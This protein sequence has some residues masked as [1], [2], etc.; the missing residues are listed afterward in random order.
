MVAHNSKT[1]ESSGRCE[2]VGDM[3]SN[4]C[5]FWFNI[6]CLWNAVSNCSRIWMRA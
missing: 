3:R 2:L 1:L 6:F 4:K 5:P